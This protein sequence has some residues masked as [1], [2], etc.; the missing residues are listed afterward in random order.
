MSQ[1]HPFHTANNQE[2]VICQEIRLSNFTFF[3][4]RFHLL[5]LLLLLVNVSHASHHLLHRRLLYLHLH[6]DALSGVLLLVDAPVKNLQ[7]RELSARVSDSSRRYRGCRVFIVQQTRE[8]F[9]ER[10]ST[11]R[12]RLVFDKINSFSDRHAGPDILVYMGNITALRTSWLLS[13]ERKSFNKNRRCCL[14]SSF[15]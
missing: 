1:K 8:S 6:P 3:S 14:M 11:S 12:L 4:S 9:G 10:G 5:G 2:S 7:T 15:N 13:G